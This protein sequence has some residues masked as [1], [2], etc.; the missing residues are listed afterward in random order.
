MF[1]I[2]LWFYLR[3]YGTL[4]KISSINIGNYSRIS[5]LTFR[6]EKCLLLHKLSRCNTFQSLFTEAVFN[7]ML[8]R[9]HRTNDCSEFVRFDVIS[10]Y[11]DT[12]TE[13]T[14]LKQWGMYLVDNHSRFGTECQIYSLKFSWFYAATL[15]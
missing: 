13:A 3:I 15:G 7:I 12:N 4:N 8:N 6:S 5:G 10:Y 14:V 11:I 9:W 1:Y 2:L